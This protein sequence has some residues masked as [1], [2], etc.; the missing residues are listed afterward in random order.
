[1]MQPGRSVDSGRRPR[2]IDSARRR[3]TSSSGPMSRARITVIVA[4]AVAVGIIG[5]A[6]GVASRACDGGFELYFWSG[7]VALLALVALP[8]AARVSRSSMARVVWALGFLAL[9]AAAWLVG[10]SSANVRFICG[11]GY[12]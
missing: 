9:G 8:F 11:L 5:L 2:S 10:L 4:A 7:C 6:F 12:L 3:V 1:M